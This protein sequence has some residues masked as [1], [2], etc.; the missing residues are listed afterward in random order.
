[1][2]ETVEH[3]LHGLS[4]Q[5]S[6]IGENFRNPVSFQS[7]AIGNP[8]SHEQHETHSYTYNPSGSN[9]DHILLQCW[10]TIYSPCNSKPLKR[11]FD[12][13]LRVKSGYYD[14]H[15]CSANTK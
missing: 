1:M 10:L 4:H 2:E 9:I 12:L 6:I 7:K 15:G 11:T 14:V 3:M 13:I 5:T 8:T